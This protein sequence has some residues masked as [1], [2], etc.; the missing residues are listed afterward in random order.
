[1]AVATSIIAGSIL[2]GGMLA[3]AKIQSN[4]ANHAADAATQSNDKSEAFL[5]KKDAEDRTQFDAT[6]RAN[7]DQYL[8]KYAAAQ[9]LGGEYGLNL[10]DAKPYVPTAYA[11]QPGAPGQ[12]PQGPQGGNPQDPAAFIA[13]YQSQHSPTEGPT[14][15]L[16]AMKQ[17]GFNV[18]PYMYGQTPSGNEISL[19]GSKYKVISGENGPNPGWYTAGMNDSAPGQRV[20]SPIAS[21][22]LSAMTPQMQPQTQDFKLHSINAFL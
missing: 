4:A 9:R 12:P 21:T 8:T 13:Q 5:E 10:P 17:A 20:S 18:A 11:G 6:Q 3:S 7:Y 15:I 19:N 22:Y 2:A 1:M 16:N 14:G